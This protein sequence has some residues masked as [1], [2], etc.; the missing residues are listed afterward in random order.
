MEGMLGE[1][2]N[3]V[4]KKTGIQGLFAKVKSWG[5]EFFQPATSTWV[6]NIPPQSINQRTAVSLLITNF[7]SLEKKLLLF[8]SCSSSTKILNAVMIRISFISLIS[9]ASLSFVLY[10]VSIEALTI[11]DPD[12]Q[13]KSS[14]RAAMFLRLTYDY[15]SKM[16]DWTLID[17]VGRNHRTNY[18]RAL[19]GKG[20]KSV[21]N[22]K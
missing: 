11:H 14:F 17:R 15:E 2:R 6:V 16:A 20:F 8:F 21:L 1:A 18:I 22:W 12:T 3:G 10:L 4:K 5:R 9:F 13:V 7:H 19:W